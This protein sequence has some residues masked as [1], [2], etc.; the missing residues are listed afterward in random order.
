MVN[1]YLFL[2]KWDPSLIAITFN[3]IMS[4]LFEYQVQGKVRCQREMASVAILILLSE[5]VLRDLP[6]EWSW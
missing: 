6:I 1:G 4:V 2:I 3:L 5:D